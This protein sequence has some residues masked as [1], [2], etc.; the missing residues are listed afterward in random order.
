MSFRVAGSST[1]LCTPVSAS[2]PKDFSLI[3]HTN[4]LQ[5]V[6]NTLPQVQALAGHTKVYKEMQSFITTLYKAGGHEAKCF[7]FLFS[8]QLD[9]IC[10]V[11]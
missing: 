3:T 10:G 8:V 5:I 11:M 1:Y 9:T 4:S 6:L 2:P 7:I